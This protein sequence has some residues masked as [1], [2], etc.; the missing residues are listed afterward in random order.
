MF[1]LLQYCIKLYLVI[2]LSVQ[3]WKYFFSSKFSSSG[4]DYLLSITFVPQQAPLSPHSTTSGGAG[5]GAA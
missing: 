2:H 5:S 1:F 3:N 4:C